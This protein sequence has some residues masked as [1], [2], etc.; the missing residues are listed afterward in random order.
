ML[1]QLHEEFNS[2]QRMLDELKEFN[3]SLVLEQKRLQCE[4]ETLRMRVQEKEI[5]LQKLI[6]SNEKTE[7]TSAELRDFEEALAQQL[8]SLHSLRTMFVQNL[9]T[10]VEKSTAPDCEDEESR[11]LHKHKV[12]FLENNLEQLSK[13]HK[14]VNTQVLTSRHMIS[15]SVVQLFIHMTIS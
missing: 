3:E 11:V 15:E 13:V 7:H 14:Q 10:H 4:Y 9:T 2:K 6:V 12:S 8:R 5:N 1:V